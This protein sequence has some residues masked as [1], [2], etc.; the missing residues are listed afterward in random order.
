[1]N[2]SLPTVKELEKLPLRAVVAYAARTA[3]RISSE[4]RGIVADDILEDALRH[5]ETVLTAD[6]I[7]EIDQASVISAGERVAAAYADAPASVKSPQSDLKVFS[8]VQAALA[9][10]YAIEGACDPSNARH[11]IKRAAQAA[12]RA[13]R[14]IQALDSSVASVVGEAARQDYNI[15]LRKYGEHDKVVIGD[16]IDCFDDG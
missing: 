14:C 16:P 3:R 6:L 2:D 10:M 9:A 7:G 15:L 11:Q 12:Q 5:V 8:L 4:L 13:V 1:M